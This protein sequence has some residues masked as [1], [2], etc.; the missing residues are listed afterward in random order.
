MRL[1]PDKYNVLQGGEA[2]QWN[3]CPGSVTYA[4]WSNRFSII[5]FLWNFSQPVSQNKPITTHYAFGETKGR[6][7]KTH[8]I[9]LNM[10]ETLDKC[11]SSLS[12][13]NISQAA[14]PDRADIA[15]TSI[16]LIY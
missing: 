16:I 10:T 11:Q 15:E 3:A 13:R 4:T 5:F 12:D 8:S 6:P 2:T 7:P 1:P 9:I 14:L